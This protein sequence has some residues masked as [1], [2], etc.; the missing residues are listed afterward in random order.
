[1][2]RASGVYAL[3]QI[4]FVPGCAAEYGRR[5]APAETVAD[6]ERNFTADAASLTA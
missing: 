1:M 6:V 5:L 4:D 2:G 3:E